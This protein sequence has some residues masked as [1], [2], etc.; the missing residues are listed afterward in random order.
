VDVPVGALA[1]DVAARVQADESGKAVGFKVATCSIFLLDAAGAHHP[2]D[3][4]AA[5]PA[6]PGNPA[7]PAA[8]ST[9]NVWI[10]TPAP[11]EALGAWQLG[12]GLGAVLG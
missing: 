5:F 6:A 2:M 12:W 10:E 11:G 7:P 9:V 1:E 3:P 4:E 8:G